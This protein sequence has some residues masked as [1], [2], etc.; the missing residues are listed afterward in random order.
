MSDNFHETY[1]RG[2]P[3]AM[4]SDKSTGLV[5]AGALVIAAVLFRNT[6]AI[7][8]PASA[9]AVTLGT[10]ALLKPSVLAPVTLGWFRLGLLL[11]KIVSPIILFALFAVVIVPY[12]LAMQLVRDPLRRRAR[13]SGTASYWIARDA[14]ASPPADLRR[15][16]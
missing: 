11:N 3:I 4:P 6:A 14:T 15:Q 16:F 8:L 5:L 10:L 1:E 7:A 13:R 9:V 2:E 12:G